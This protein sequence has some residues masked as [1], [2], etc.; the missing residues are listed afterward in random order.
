MRAIPKIV[1][2]GTY[3]FAEEIETFREH[4]HDLTKWAKEAQ[5]E[6]DVA[7]DMLDTLLIKDH[8]PTNIDVEFTILTKRHGLMYYKTFNKHE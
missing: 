2:H 4:N 7:H 8:H 3:T 6:I 5:K 1:L